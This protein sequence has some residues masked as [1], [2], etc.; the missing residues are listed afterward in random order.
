MNSVLL[1]P[2]GQREPQLGHA[3]QARKMSFEQKLW[4]GPELFEWSC[5]WALAG[6]R[7]QFPEANDERARQILQERLAL[8]NRL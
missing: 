7:H 5:Q 8:Q 6:I 3:L 1:R 4:A 2:R